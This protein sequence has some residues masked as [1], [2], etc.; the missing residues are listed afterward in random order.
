M[1]K[2]GR[3]RAVRKP[4]RFSCDFETTVYTGQEYTEVW[5]AAAVELGTEDVRIFHD[6]GS[7]FGYMF[8]QGPHVIAYFHNL[9]F[10]GTFIMSY[11]LERGDWK[12]AADGSLEDGT[13]AWVPD[14]DMRSKTFKYV[15]SADMGNWYCMTLKWKG[16]KLEIRDSLKLLP[17]SVKRIGESFGTRHKKLDMEYKG[18]RYAGCPI[19]DEEKR[20]I[21]N[22]VLVV[23]EALEIMFEEGHDRL[24]IGSCCL[25]EFKSTLLSDEYDLYFPDVYAMELDESV[26]GSPNVG[27]WIRK[28]YRGGWCYV[29]PGKSK[30]R[31]GA[32]ITCDVNSL[33][34]SVMHSDSGSWYPVGEP[35]FWVG[36]FIPD[37]C[38]EPETYWFVR[39]RTRFYQK[40]GMLPTVQIKRNPLY[41]ATKWLETSDVY[42]RRNG[43]YSPVYMKDGAMRDAIVEMTLTCTDFQLLRDHYDLVDFEVLDGCWFAARKGIFD[44]YIDH[45][46]EIKMTSKGAKRES[47]KLFLN[48]LYGKMATS[49]ESSFKVAYLGEDGALKYA[50]VEAHDKKPGYIPVGSAITSYARNF[51]IRAA[52]KNY[53]GPDAPGFCYADTDSIHCDMPE[54]ELAGVPIHPT[55]FCHWKVESH[56]DEAF[57]SRQKTYI[58]HVT[59]EDGKPVEPYYN[60]KCA[61]MPARPKLLFMASLSGTDPGFEMTEEEREFVSKRRTLEDFDVGLS[62]PGKLKAT[63]VRGGTVLMDTPYVMHEGLIR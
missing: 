45:Y 20:Y 16:V 40:P 39:I 18:F 42:D 26:H 57:F 63:L 6:I 7:W 1:G 34:P 33:Y 62:V 49:P 2:A 3:T 27:E 28:S 55:E 4:R 24:T 61:G 53:H 44:R 59:V 25:K 10:D 60:V 14:K 5:A 48:N 13:F 11:L 54:E 43:C 17:F 15:I 52:Q 19:T 46:R 36:D 58:E 9:K 47:A 29:V 22:D 51:T 23:K 21:A 38:F 8:E 30:R 50:A 31:T 41:P 32:G 37:R 12:L 56:W 35:V